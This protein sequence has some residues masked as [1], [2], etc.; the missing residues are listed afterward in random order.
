MGGYAIVISVGRGVGVISLKGGMRGSD[1]GEAERV[2]M[3]SLVYRL[4]GSSHCSVGQVATKWTTTGDRLNWRES[5]GMLG[6]KPKHRVQL[7]EDQRHDLQR[8]IAAGHDSARELA[9]ARI[10]LKTDENPGGPGWRDEEIACALDVSTATIEWVRKRFVADG[11]PAAV[12]Q[13]RPVREYRRALDG[14][15][16]AHPIALSCSE[17]PEGRA[18]WSMQWLANRLVELRVVEAV[19]DETVR[20]T[21]K[22]TYSRRGFAGNSA[23]RRRPAASSPGGW[24]TSSTSIPARMTRGAP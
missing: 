22:R 4:G 14:E 18:R 24:R 11:L 8:R 13:K 23:F 15:A 12:R 21:L 5:C 1:L 7:S 19:S 2:A 6:M 20:R 10:I 16:E 17:P 3:Q 9:H